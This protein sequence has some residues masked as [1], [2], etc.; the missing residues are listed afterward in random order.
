MSGPP[1]QLPGYVWDPQTRRYFKQATSAI[2]STPASTARAATAAT[3]AQRER[4]K[5]EQ[6]VQLQN[7]KKAKQARERKLKRDDEG[8]DCEDAVIALRNSILAPWITRTANRDNLKHGLQGLHLATKLGS[9]RTVYPDCLPMDDSIQHIS[10]DQRNPLTL[11][12]GTSNGTIATGYLARPPDEIDMYPNDEQG[13]RTGWFCSSKITSLKTSGDRIVATCLGPPA[14]A[15]V[16]TTNDNISLASI[17]LSPRKTSLWTS[18]I[19]RDIVALGGDRSVLL[20]PLSSLSSSSGSSTPSHPEGGGMDAYMTGGRG[21][22]GTVFALEIDEPGRV[23]FAGVRRG[24]V[25]GFDWRSK[26]GGGGGS[27]GGGGGGE[28]NIPLSTPITH[29]RIV[30]GQPHQLLVG[31]MGGH[32]AIYDLRS[33]RPPRTSTSTSAPDFRPRKGLPHGRDRNGATGG[34]RT[35]VGV[36]A[37]APIPV[38]KMEGHVNTFSTELGMDLWQDEWVA[39]AGQD[40]RLRIFSLRSGLPLTP[41]PSATSTPGSSSLWSSSSPSTS[42]HPLTRTFSEPLRS[43]AFSPIDPLRLREKDYTRKMLERSGGAAHPEEEDQGGRFGTRWDCPSL[44][45]AEGA[46]VECLAVQ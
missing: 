35:G 15:I 2:R 5:L 14:Q 3:L 20:C 12:V 34:G 40:S 8:E 9:V 46:G 1:L 36:H 43:V 25:K 29:L 30:P 21:G 39:I 24:D 33:L 26:R 38:V 22:G 27:G 32:L 10:F 23:V 6:E 42:A 45:I 13:W 11:R 7:K 18:A 41:P 28:I 31:A 44:W 16:G 4:T 19:S 17:T 37:A